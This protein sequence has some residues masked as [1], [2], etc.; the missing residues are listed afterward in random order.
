MA[1]SFKIPAR[2]EFTSRRAQWEPASARIVGWREREM[3]DGFDLDY[4]EAEVLGGPSEGKTFSLSIEGLPEE[5]WH[6]CATGDEETDVAFACQAFTPEIIVNTSSKNQRSYPGD[7]WA[8][9]EEFLQISPKT[10]QIINFLNKWGYWRGRTIQLVSDIVETHA[11]IRKALVASP[12]KWL[13]SHHSILPLMLRRKDYPFFRMDTDQCELAI[14]TVT[15]IDLLNNVKFGICA[16]PDCR[17]V[18]R[19]DSKHKRGY[20]KQ[21]CGHLESMRRKRAKSPQQGLSG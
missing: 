20:C 3:K 17:T 2:F 10:G 6:I 13:G 8:M 15:T 1:H 11:L 18:Y 5:L 19:I 21:Y 9:Q 16:R 14:R 4:L 7:A 12:E